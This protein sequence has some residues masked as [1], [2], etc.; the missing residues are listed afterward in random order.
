MQVSKKR[1]V[2]GVIKFVDD[3]LIPQIYDG[4]VRFVLSMIKDTMKKKP[5]MIDTFL[6]NSIISSSISENDGMYEIGHFVD[7]MRGILEEC[8]SYPITIPKVP[9]LSPD[10]KIVRINANDFEKLVNAIWS[11]ESVTS[12]DD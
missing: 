12:A 6:D 10:E 7:T 9:L 3:S 5:N 2:D 8:E 1:I 4:Q 11:D